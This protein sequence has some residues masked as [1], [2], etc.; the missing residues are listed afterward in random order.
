MN[1]SSSFRPVPAEPHRNGASLI[2]GASRG[3]GL[4][5]TETLLTGHSDN[6]VIATHRPGGLSAELQELETRYPGRLHLLPLDFTSE[7]S[8]L[9][10]RRFLQEWP[11]GVDLALHA[12]GLL[13]KGEIQPEKTITQCQSDHLLRLF[14]VNS[15]GP[16]MVAQTL[17][18]T[19]PRTRR[20]T[21]VAL[22]AMVGSIGDN[23]LGGW[24]G[25]RASKSALNQFIRTLS[26]ECRIK[27]P[28]AAII[29]MHPGTTDT[30]LSKPFQR[31]VAPT[32][33]YTP[34]QTASRILNVISQLDESDSG[35][36]FNWDGQQIPW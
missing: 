16:L 8:L 29:A 27:F 18:L 30:G 23:R 35:H 13:H 22:S 32:K 26:I 12:A 19:Q 5:L 6:A 1:Q 7:K 10:L 25:Y 24:Y 34:D 4:A 33:L 36:F 28:N 15:I 14:E 2:V 17:L 20:F 11:D 9:D 3:I 21:F 31:N